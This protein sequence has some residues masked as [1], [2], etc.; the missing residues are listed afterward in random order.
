MKTRI[1][2]SISRAAPCAL[3]AIA[4]LAPPGCG[5]S[6]ELAATEAGEEARHDEGA[7]PAIAVSPEQIAAAGIE[8]ET[9]AAG[10]VDSDIELLGEVRPNGD[11]LA[12]IVPR[13]PGVVREVRK[14]VGDRVRSGDVLAVV[15]SSESLAPYE[16][17]T[18]IDGVVIDKHL[19]RGEA[20]D[21]D[22]QTFVIA[23]LGTVWVELGV[24]QRDL[25]RVHAGQAVRIESG[26]DGMRADGV[27]AYVTPS[28]DEA[29]RT[30][31]ARI[32][33]P[34][35]ESRWRPGMFVTARVLDPKPVPVAIPRS[36]VQSVDGRPVVFVETE[37]GFEP[38]PVSLGRQGEALVE[39]LSGLAPGERYAARG[40]FLLKAELGK[41]EAEHEE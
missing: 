31:T 2:R 6:S 19:T 4:L 35:P 29:T 26:A 28:L 1:H 9:A 21:R 39:A 37:D 41:S 30:A 20:V 3:L 8:L 32:V 7:P 38:R 40:S 17:K 22:K 25:E 5:G 15:E 18:L 24:Y 16:L 34:N 12:H 23:D 11:H 36:A 14:N 10:S 13:F 33:L 27:I